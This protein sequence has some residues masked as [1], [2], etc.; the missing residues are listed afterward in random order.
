MYKAL[1]VSMLALLLFLPLFSV[2]TTRV[3]DELQLISVIGFDK[4]EEGAIKGTVSLTSY[5]VEEETKN[6]ALSAESNSTRA[7]RLKF[8]SMS[9]RPL[10][11]GKISSILLEDQLAEGG[12]FDVLDTY[13]RD[14]T[15]ATKAYLSVT[16][17][18]TQG[19][20]NVQF[21]LQ[22][23]I[24]A[25]LK[26]MLDHNITQGNLPQSNMHLFMRAYFEQGHDPFL[27]YLSYSDR[28]LQVDGIA[29]FKQD[30]LIDTLSLEESFLLKLLTDGYDKGGVIE[31]QLDEGEHVAVLRELRSDTD[32]HVDLKTRT[33]FIDVGLRTRLSEYSGGLLQ[34]EKLQHITSEANASL[35][36]GMK[37]LLQNLQEKEVDPIGFGARQIGKNGLNEEEWYQ[38]YSKLAVD[39]RVST[40]IV[41]SGVS[42]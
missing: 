19:L 1:K 5:S 4:G 3:I 7:L 15:V 34:E 25:Y 33:L 38:L 18:T 29:L 8:N 32:V 21:P 31:I 26:D 22:S 36:E 20:L 39:V 13:Y 28:N 12:I 24:G 42:Q 2:V 6:T 17:G 40:H 10:H 30:R 14:P 41:E 16:N 9:S 23:E 11:G 35:Q 37:R 27:P